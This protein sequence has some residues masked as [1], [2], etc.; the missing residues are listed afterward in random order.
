ML[1]KE[2]KK[3]VLILKYLGV[4]VVFVL[5]TGLRTIISRHF[6][7]YTTH[8]YYKCHMCERG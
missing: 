3:V 6:C 4:K 1:K 5:Q 7:H 8:L 2:E